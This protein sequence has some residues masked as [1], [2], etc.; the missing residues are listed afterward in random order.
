MFDL[1]CLELLTVVATLKESRISRRWRI[2]TK[3]PS[4]FI[5][6][7]FTLSWSYHPLARM[8]GREEALGRERKRPANPVRLLSRAKRLARGGRDSMAGLKPNA[9]DVWAPLAR[10]P[11]VP[12]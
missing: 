9:R 4:P 11:C 5:L 12:T 10:P 6:S 8:I 3:V 1:V 2:S 7:V